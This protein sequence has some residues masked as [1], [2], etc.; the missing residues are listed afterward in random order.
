MPK[1]K[2]MQAQNQEDVRRPH[3]EWAAQK[4][5]PAWLLAA[6]RAKAGWALGQEMTEREFDRVVEAALKEVIR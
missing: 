6:A 2:E 3:E 4:G 5:T 1:E